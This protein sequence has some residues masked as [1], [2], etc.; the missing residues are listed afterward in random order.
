MLMSFQV[1]NKRLHFRKE[2]VAKLISLTLKAPVST[3]SWEY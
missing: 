1:K 3:I 2:N